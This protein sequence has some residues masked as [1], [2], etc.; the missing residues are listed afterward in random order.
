MFSQ[1]C[2]NIQCII[3]LFSWYV[4]YLENGHNFFLNVSPTLREHPINPILKKAKNGKVRL[5]VSVSTS[6]NSPN[7]KFTLFSVFN[8]C[9]TLALTFRNLPLIVAPQRSSQIFISIFF[10]GGGKKKTRKKQYVLPITTCCNVAMTTTPWTT[11]VYLLCG[12]TSLQDVELL[13]LLA[14]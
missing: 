13:G 6:V 1:S 12:L 2:G 5:R 3:K 8:Q 14:T 11:T 10:S 9:P 4:Q 7:K